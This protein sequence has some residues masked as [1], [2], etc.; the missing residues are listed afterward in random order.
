VLSASAKDSSTKAER[1]TIRQGTEYYNAGNY[2]EALREYERALTI[3]PASEYA[4]Y[5]K[6]ATL[7]Q[8]ASDDNKGKENDPRVQ[9]AE[10]FHQIAESKTNTKLAEYSWYNLGNMSFNDENYGE[11]IKCYKG[12][13]RINPDNRKARQNLLLA[14][15]KQE[16]QQQNKDNQDQQQQQDQDKQQ[17]QQQQQQQ[18]QQQQQQDQQQQQ[19]QQ[20]QPQQQEMTQDAQQIL[21]SIQ[22]KENNTR[23]EQEQRQRV[24]GHPTTDKPW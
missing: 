21:Q 5:N 6:A 12:A 15:K 2:H 11:A 3:N 10:L 1:N 8:L 18:D 19:Q 20:Q 17:Q 23:K 13:L 4:I 9:A 22:N 7:V 14:L 16:E 24:N